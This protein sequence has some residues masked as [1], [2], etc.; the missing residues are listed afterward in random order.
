MCMHVQPRHAATATSSH[1]RATWS[2]RPRSAVPQCPAMAASAGAGSLP[3][4]RVPLPHARVTAAAPTKAMHRRLFRPLLLRRRRSRLLRVAQGWGA[5][6]G[7]GATPPPHL[8][9]LPRHCTATDEPSIGRRTYFLYRCSAPRMRKRMKG[10]N[11][12]QKFIQ[13]SYCEYVTHRNSTDCTAG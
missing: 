13:G 3:R 6:R 5:T 2:G 1:G 8:P 10:M 12:S 11:P 4:A 7:R 9:V